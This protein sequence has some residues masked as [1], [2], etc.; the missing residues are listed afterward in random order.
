MDETWVLL[1]ALLIMAA[2]VGKMVSANLLGRLGRETERLEQGRKIILERLQK[3][4]RRRKSAQSNKEFMERRRAEIIEQLGQLKSQL[5]EPKDEEAVDSM[6]GEGAEDGAGE[7]DATFAGGEAEETDGGHDIE[8]AEKEIVEKEIK[9]KNRT[10][11]P[12]S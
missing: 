7:E 6:T 11:R 5:Q 12:F 3:I 9:V 8:E 2:I 4:R 1:A 10:P